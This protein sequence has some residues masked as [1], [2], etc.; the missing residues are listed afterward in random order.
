MTN[1]NGKIGPNREM[2]LLLYNIVFWRINWHVGAPGPGALFFI[3]AVENNQGVAK[4]R[5][6]QKVPDEEKNGQNIRPTSGRYRKNQDGKAAKFGKV[7]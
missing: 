6:R 1:M 2:S 7:F 4:G 3:S 5:A